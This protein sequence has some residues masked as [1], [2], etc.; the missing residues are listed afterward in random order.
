MIE[1]IALLAMVSFNEVSSLIASLIA[2]V[3]LVITLFK[4]DKKEAKDNAVR[5]SKLEGDI[6]ELREKYT[7]MSTEVNKLSDTLAL[8]NTKQQVMNVVLNQVQE[9]VTELLNY[10]RTTITEFIKTT[11]ASLIRLETISDMNKEK[12]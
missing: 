4:D 9:N 7:N 8:I 12:S 11:Q 5:V 1:T 10:N 2:G 6:L 3:A